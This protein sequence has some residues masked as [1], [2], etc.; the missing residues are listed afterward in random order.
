M[1]K[2]FWLMIISSFIIALVILIDDHVLE[3]T[4]FATLFVYDLLGFS[5]AG[6][7]L[8]IYQPWRKEI[9]KSLK[10]AKLKK[11]LL[12]F[13]SDTFDL[14]GHILYKLALISAPSAALVSVVM[15][16]QP[17]YLLT[18]S[19][20]L[21]IFLPKIIKE[22]ISIKNIYKKTIGVTII[23]IGVTIISIF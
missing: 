6:L 5:L 11:Y 8:F 10:E 23:F 3:R 20:L 22:D 9:L 7:S 1:N 17:F 16:I 4:S 21:T 18:M 19:I 13:L 2:P 15:G 14:S 12:F